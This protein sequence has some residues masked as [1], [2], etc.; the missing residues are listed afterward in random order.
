MHT[1]ACH[2]TILRFLFLPGHKQRRHQDTHLG[3]PA[4]KVNMLSLYH[5]ASNFIHSSG[6]LP[7]PAIHE[8]AA[9]TIWFSPY[10]V[11]STPSLYLGRKSVAD[12]NYSRAS[13]RRVPRQITRISYSHQRT[14][15]KLPRSYLIL[16]PKPEGHFSALGNRALPISR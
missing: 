10:G 2:E 13:L 14:R 3:E 7:H 15:H 4:V 9:V 11:V 16:V 5:G 1:G 6:R 12:S 8:A